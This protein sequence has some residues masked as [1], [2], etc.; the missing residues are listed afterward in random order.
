M[1]NKYL[2]Y[3][4]HFQ[5]SKE[6]KRDF[7]LNAD[8]FKDVFVNYQAKYLFPLVPTKPTNKYLYLCG[9]NLE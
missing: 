5:K 2:S 4:L 1:Y 3:R 9:K 6:A 7:H 8:I